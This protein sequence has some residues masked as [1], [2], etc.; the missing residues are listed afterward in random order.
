MTDVN[1]VT[2]RPSS[3]AIVRLPQLTMLSRTS[4]LLALHRLVEPTPPAT[5]LPVVEER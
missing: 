3:R 1:V 5:A 4:V 2:Y